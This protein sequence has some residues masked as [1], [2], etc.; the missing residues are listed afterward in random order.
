MKDIKEFGVEDAKS[1]VRA[2]MKDVFTESL[3]KSFE[4]VV[5]IEKMKRRMAVTTQELSVLIG[6]PVGTL[7][8]WRSAKKGPEYSKEGSKI[9]YP[10]KAIKLWLEQ[11]GRKTVAY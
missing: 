2:A 1:I 10:V 8:N 5:E 7:N 9:M 4:P 6:V 3:Q 11:T